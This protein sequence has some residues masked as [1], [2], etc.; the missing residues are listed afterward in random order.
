VVASPPP[1]ADG[2]DAVFD[3]HGHW[4]ELETRRPASRAGNFYAE[5]DRSLRRPGRRC[6]GRRVEKWWFATGSSC[7]L[8]RRGA[9]TRVQS[10]GAAVP[11]V[12]PFGLA[13]AVT[14]RD[15]G[16]ARRDAVL[17]LLVFAGSAQFSAVGLFAAGAGALSIVLT[18]F[19]LNVRHVLYGVS[20]TR[21]IRLTRRLA[22]IAAYFLTDEAFG[23]TV[24]GR[25]RTFRF[26]LGAEL[27]LFASWNLAT[28]A[29]APRRRRS[30]SHAAR[31]GRDLPARSSRCSC[32]SCAG[33]SSSS[34]SSRVH[35]HGCL[36]GVSR[37]SADPRD[38]DAGRCS[39]WRRDRPAPTADEIA[40]EGAYGRGRDLLAHRRAGMV[41]V[42]RLAARGPVAARGAAGILAQVSPLRPDRRL[43]RFITPSLQ[44]TRDEG[45]PGRCGLVVAAAWRTRNLGVAL[46]AG[47]RRS[48]L[49]LLSEASSVRMAHHA[50]RSRCGWRSSGPERLPS[51]SASRRRALA[52]VRSA[53]SA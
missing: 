21:T 41:A 25:G 29:G 12:V 32:R 16:L 52:T 27:S 35:S 9:R 11:G 34:R 23:V 53:A 1:Q 26:L 33:R 43:R 37:W 22:P 15:A 18:T 8:G 36:P 5:L 19:L 46:V 3:G 24:A 14:A 10:H 42:V 17:S 38:Q 39:A 49:R 6:T 31:R 47:W 28:L 51:C 4:I 40:H 2:P 50:G 20:L 45:H 30:R 7:D 13:Y 48:G 44:G